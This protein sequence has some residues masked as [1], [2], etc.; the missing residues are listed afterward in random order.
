MRLMFNYQGNFSNYS[1]ED[2]CFGAMEFDS[3]GEHYVI[4][5]VGEVDYDFSKNEIDG[6][7]K[8]EIELLSP[9]GNISEEELGDIIMNMDKSTFQYNILDD[10]DVPPFR[11]F[12]CD[13]CFTTTESHCLH[14]EKLGTQGMTV[15]QFFDRLRDYPNWDVDIVI[16]N[17]RTK[18]LDDVV[19]IVCDERNGNLIIVKKE[20]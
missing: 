20:N 16:E 13:I 1:K 19:D 8:G 2:L 15:R 7:F 4:D 3:N 9:I 6:Q 5:L 18:M 10:G 17:Q 14:I 11:K 12:E